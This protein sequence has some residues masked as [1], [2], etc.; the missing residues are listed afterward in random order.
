MSSKFRQRCLLLFIFIIV[1]L[2]I[3]LFSSTYQMSS[4][5]ATASTVERVRENNTAKELE[6]QGKYFYSIGQFEQAA[7][8]WQQAVRI[9]PHQDTIS[10]ARVLSNLA[11]AHS[12]LNNWSQA[13]DNIASSLDLLR[14]DTRLAFD[15]RV[16]A[17]AQTLNNQGIL[18]LNEGKAEEAIALWSEAKD[19][20]QQAGD[21]LGVIRASTSRG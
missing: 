16:S 19:N 5:F 20:Y 13:T 18:Q 11:L 8:L 9:Y 2:S 12:Q 6:A 4:V 21:E 15:E 7:D 10:Q 14:R 17:L 1:G 3:G